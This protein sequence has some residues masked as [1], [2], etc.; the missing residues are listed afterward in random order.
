MCRWVPKT[1]VL[2]GAYS[3]SHGGFTLTPA[4]NFSKKATVVTLAKKLGARQTLKGS[5]SLK[6]QSAVLEL[7]VA[8]LTV[9]PCF[10]CLS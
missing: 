10:I 9:S 7:G 4:H 8:P 3:L 1:N 2:L 5:Y 6:D